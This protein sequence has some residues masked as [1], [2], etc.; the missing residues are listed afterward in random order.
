M[1]KKKKYLEFAGGWY[2]ADGAGDESMVEVAGSGLQKYGTL[3]QTLDHHVFV[4]SVHV[5]SYQIYASQVIFLFILFILL[6]KLGTGE[7]TASI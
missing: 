7:F 3:A 5:H 6:L 4:N 1:E 2:L